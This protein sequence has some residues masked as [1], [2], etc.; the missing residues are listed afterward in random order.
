MRVLRDN[1]FGRVALGQ[2]LCRNR[3]ERRNRHNFQTGAERQALRYR[4]RNAHANER[5]RSVAKDY[6]IYGAERD[7]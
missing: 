7:A 1:N 2:H 6:R 3:G 5:A 4:R